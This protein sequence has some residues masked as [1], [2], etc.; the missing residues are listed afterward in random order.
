[1]SD[2]E[3]PRDVT[4]AFIQSPGDRI[5]S[6]IPGFVAAQLAPIWP[7]REDARLDQRHLEFAAYLYVTGAFVEDGGP[8]PGDLLMLDRI[9]TMLFPQLEGDEDLV[10]GDVP[11]LE[12][13]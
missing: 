2:R 13:A 12:E 1:M 3:G 5:C 10:F 6:R 9:H 11:G 7:A 8:E 4:G